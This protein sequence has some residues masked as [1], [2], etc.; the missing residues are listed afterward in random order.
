VSLT[1]A[2]TADAI[3]L[4][5]VFFWAWRSRLDLGLRAPK[6][7]RTVWEWSGLF[8][9][10]CAAEW[11]VVA[12][13]GVETDPEWIDLGLELT[14]AQALV[15]TV[16]VGPLTEELL[17]RGALFASLFR[18]WGAAA[19]LLVPSLLWGLTHLQYELWYG[20]SIAGSGVVLAV[21][22]WKSGSLWLP[23]LLHAAF[24]LAA[25]VAPPLPPR[26]G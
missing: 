1:E 9:L 18:R 25:A 13:H 17:F 7:D 8:I 20:A 11:A 19:A 24:N 2:L 16:L 3:I 26:P 14:L 21:I 5:I 15:L 10:W 6:F 4:A 22:R 23:F 12:A